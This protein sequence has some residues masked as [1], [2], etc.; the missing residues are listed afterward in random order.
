M[1]QAVVRKR[2]HS[3]GSATFFWVRLYSSVISSYFVA[4][5]VASYL[6]VLPCVASI[7]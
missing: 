2:C 5:G 7:F 3:C 1:R 6:L 4:I